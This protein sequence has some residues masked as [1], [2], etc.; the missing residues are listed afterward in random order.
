MDRTLF[1]HMVLRKIMEN[2]NNKPTFV[3][4]IFFTN[5]NISFFN[6]CSDFFSIIAKKVDQIRNNIVCVA[7]SL[8]FVFCCALT[9]DSC[10]AIQHNF[11]KSREIGVLRPIF[12]ITMLEW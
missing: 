4:T 8:V 1:L 6:T 5:I 10:N 9:T 7:A 11:R 3:S 12:L 2:T